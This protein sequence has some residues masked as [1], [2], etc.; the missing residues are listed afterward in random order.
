MGL[1]KKRAAETAEIERLKAEI[2]AMASRL[3]AADQR[4]DAAN[5]RLDAADTAK[6]ELGARVQG[7]VTR[8]DTPIA[9]PPEPPPPPPPTIDPAELTAVRDRLDEIVT[10]LDGVD[11]RIT[12]VSTELAH[13][14]D[15]LSGEIDAAGPRTPPTDDIVDELRDA[16]TRLANEQARY[17]IAFRQDLADLADRLRRH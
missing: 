12:A 2:A 1:F 11:A 8:L 5:Q 13:Q 15:E 9:P 6:T 10:R 3:E 17:Q 16:Q 4:L 14:I 7:I